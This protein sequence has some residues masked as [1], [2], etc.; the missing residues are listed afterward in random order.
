MTGFKVGDKVKII[1][2]VDDYL[3]QSIGDVGIITEIYTGDEKYCFTY[4][5]CVKFEHDEN[6]MYYSEIARV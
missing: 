4:D 6:S 3:D 5:C 1:K 2:K